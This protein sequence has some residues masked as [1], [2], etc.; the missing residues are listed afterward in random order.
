M[1][2]GMDAQT[3]DSTREPMSQ[4]VDRWMSDERTNEQRNEHKPVLVHSC[5]HG[6]RS[7]GGGWDFSANLR[8]TCERHGSRNSLSN[9]SV[10]NVHIM[11]IWM[12]V[13][14]VYIYI[15]STWILLIF[16]YA[17]IYDISKR[18]LRSQFIP[19]HILP[20]HV[21]SHNPWQLWWLDHRVHFL[22]LVGPNLQGC[23]SFFSLRGIL[24]TCASPR[25][26][27]EWVDMNLP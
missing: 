22:V 2:G 4:W 20:H 12:Y 18:A 9:T 6:L 15:H 13:N 16:I 26:G 23:T 25:N 1:H 10:S 11:M 19:Y 3:K 27:H 14:M 17:Y 5:L 8:Q 24:Q 7:H 21:I